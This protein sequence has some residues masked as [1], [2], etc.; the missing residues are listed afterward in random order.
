MMTDKE[1][2]LLI[3]YCVGENGDCTYKPTEDDIQEV[4]EILTTIEDINCQM[5]INEELFCEVA[6]H[7]Y[8]EKI[9]SRYYIVDCWNKY[10]RGMNFLDKGNKEKKEIL[11]TYDE[12]IVPYEDE[13][14]ITEDEVKT[15][16]LKSGF[17]IDDRDQVR[18]IKKRLERLW[19][20]KSEMLVPSVLEKDSKEWEGISFK[21][22][23][24]CEEYIKT[25]KVK[26]TCES[27]G[28]GRTTAFEY[29]KD[30]EVQEYLQERKK[31]IK[32]ESEKLFEQGL[33]EAF[34]E[35]LKII[36][37]DSKQECVLNRKVKAIDTYLRHYENIKRPK[38]SELN[39]ISQ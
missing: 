14:Y 29:L 15:L 3:D 8:D 6:S 7:I 31:E 26:A 34:E 13:Y 20:D 12:I 19:K 23:L 16:L 32:E 22:F 11:E 4:K 35:L 24:F 27:L 30:K 38:A 28:I 39:E 36:K 33:N 10:I 5:M 25:G 21:K 37:E 18:D 9:R 1:K 2:Q 17:Q